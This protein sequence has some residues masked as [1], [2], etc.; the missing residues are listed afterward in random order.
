MWQRG[1]RR[2]KGFRAKAKNPQLAEIMLEWIE[3][4]HRKI[5][6]KTKASS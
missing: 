3:N 4:C 6:V 1:L 5:K 2:K